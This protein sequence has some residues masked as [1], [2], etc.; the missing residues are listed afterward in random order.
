MKQGG[1]PADMASNFMA[2]PAV[3]AL[4]MRN[5]TLGE[6]MVYCCSHPGW[7]NHYHLVEYTFLPLALP[8]LIAGWTGKA[9]KSPA[10]QH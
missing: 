3:D 2:A 6:L 10:G 4:L 9:P 8:R 5:T 7:Q 1:L